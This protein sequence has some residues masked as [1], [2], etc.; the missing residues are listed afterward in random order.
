MAAAA[1][2]EGSPPPSV[3]EQLADKLKVIADLQD[4]LA[5]YPAD[6]PK[7]GEQPNV[8]VSTEVAGAL[9]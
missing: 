5:N 3:V 7:T 9:A 4:K 8:T 1:P 2:A 6:K